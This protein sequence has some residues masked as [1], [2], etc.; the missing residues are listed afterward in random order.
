M[1][2]HMLKNILITLLFLIQTINSSGQSVVQNFQNALDSAYY[3]NNLKDEKFYIELS[4]GLLNK[5]EDDKPYYTA[6]YYLTLASILNGAGKGKEKE[7]DETINKCAEILKN[8]PD[9]LLTHDV[10]FFKAK[11]LVEKR[12]YNEAFST[13]LKILNVVR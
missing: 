2:S 6:E 11:V 7:V 12:N 9:S 3:S 10:N 1:E 13:F 8:Y 4:A 5:I